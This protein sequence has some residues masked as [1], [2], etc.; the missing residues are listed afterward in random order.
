MDYFVCVLFL[1]Y[2]MCSLQ[3][4]NVRY[5]F[6]SATS[7]PPLFSLSDFN[8]FLVCQVPMMLFYF[9]IIPICLPFVLCRYHGMFNYT[10]SGFFRM[11]VFFP[12][13]MTNIKRLRGMK[14]VIFWLFY[15][16]RLINEIYL[17]SRNDQLKNIVSWWG[18]VWLLSQLQVFGRVN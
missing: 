5:I 9:L 7:I 14:Y 17:C 16:C 8:I 15:Q 1:V 13:L 4:I 11:I 2:F 12:H 10:D 6:F 18:R 3:V